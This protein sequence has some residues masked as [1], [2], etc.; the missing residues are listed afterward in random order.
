MNPFNRRK[1]IKLGCKTIVGAGLMSS[2]TARLATAQSTAAD[3]YRALVCI[4][5]NGGN[6]GFNLLVPDSGAEYNEYASGRGHLAVPKSD[7]LSLNT[8]SANTTSAGLNP[9]MAELL[10]LYERGQ[11]AFM[12]NVGTLVEP[13]TPEDV[14]NKSVRL[15]EQLFSHNDQSSQWHKLDH[16][17]Q[18]NSG[19]GGRVN[20]LLAPQ[21]SNPS[22]AS[23]SLDGNNHWMSGSDASTFTISST[24]VKSY[25][26]MED[27]TNDWQMPR[28]Q[29]FI[30]LLHENYSNTFE[31]SYAELQSRA[32]VL[33]TNVGA[34]LTRFGDL[35]TPLPP[36]NELAEQLAMV[37]K[38]IA[39]K[40]EFRMTRQ[41]FYVNLGGFDTHDNQLANQPALFTKLSQALAFFN[42][43][44]AEINQLENVTSFTS[45]DFGRSITS[46]GD[47]TDHG[48]GNHHLVMG[49]SVLG[50]D[51]Y[52]QIP[53]IAVGGPD[54]ARNGRIVP[55]TSVSQYA[56]TQLSWLGLDDDQIDAMLP[57]LGNFNQ[58]NLGF[59]A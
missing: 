52:G 21:Q 19:W 1:F 11:V 42:Q 53:R 29:A 23:V 4:N 36:E 47:G 32:L 44:L 27:M 28:R 49:G 56:A 12:A 34:A 6:D 17:R 24:G 20:D 55:T 3:N 35:Q 38:L 16:N 2:A 58:R 8:A 14:R 7:L 18:W 9:H 31:R 22:L 40:D 10:P 5:L 25:S 43:A 51:I 37:A 46:N 30:Q 57:T 48:W 54:D 33:S 59:L 45:S 26:G 41:L 15:P 13:T 50:G 39:V